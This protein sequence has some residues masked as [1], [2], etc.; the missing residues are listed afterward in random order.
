MHD[1]HVLC[2]TATWEKVPQSVVCL[3]RADLEYFWALPAP[4]E[5]LF[6]FGIQ[7]TSKLYLNFHSVEFDAVWATGKL[8]LS[9]WPI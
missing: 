6:L 5:S 3:L 1:V 4:N 2:M 8:L 9:T 7:V